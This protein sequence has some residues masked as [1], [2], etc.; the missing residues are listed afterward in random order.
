[1]E[2]LE[3]IR[4]LPKTALAASFTSPSSTYKVMLFATPLKSARA[5]KPATNDSASGFVCKDYDMKKVAVRVQVS[6]AILATIKDD[7]RRQQARFLARK[8]LGRW[9]CRR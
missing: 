8:S 9:G 1:M 7:E 6:R 4:S 3:R 2:H 5:R